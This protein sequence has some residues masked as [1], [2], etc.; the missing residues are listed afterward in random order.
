MKTTIENSS[1]RRGFI[2]TTGA[3]TLATGLSQMP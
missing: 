3:A 1:T 2:R